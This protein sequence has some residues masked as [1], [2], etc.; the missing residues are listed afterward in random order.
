ML[1]TIIP[2][3]S[4]YIA[5]PCAADY[6]T[7]PICNYYSNLTLDDFNDNNNN[8]NDDDNYHYCPKCNILFDL[9]CFYKNYGIDS[10]Y[11]RKLIVEY[12]DVSGKKFEGMPIFESF[13]HV[14]SILPKMVPLFSC[15]NE[16]C[17]YHN[18]KSLN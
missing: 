1:K 8:N 10:I 16:T 6:F 17:K 9:C 5:T 15:Y 4:A 13:E 12:T 18:N 11:Y 3:E 14:N 2:P 7:C